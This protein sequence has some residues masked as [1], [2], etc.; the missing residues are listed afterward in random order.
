MKNKK[1]VRQFQKHIIITLII[2]AA[3]SVLTVLAIT[4]WRTQILPDDSELFVDITSTF[5]DGKSR[6]ETFS[7]QMKN[8]DGSQKFEQKNDVTCGSEPSVDITDDESEIVLLVGVSGA[9]ANENVLVLDPSEVQTGTSLSVANVQNGF[10]KLPK[11]KQQ[12]YTILGYLRFILPVVYSLFGII[13]SCYVFYRMHMKKTI[14]ELETA[15]EKISN[16]N[17]DFEITTSSRN[18][19][20]RLCDS[21]EQMR[22][23]L[24]KSNTEMFQMVEERRRLQS[25]V[26]HD[27]R[28]PI[29]IMKGYL[30]MMASESADCDSYKSE[31]ETLCL[32]VNRMEEY[33]D[34]VSEINKLEDM[35]LDLKEETIGECAE[36]W[37]R[38][39]ELL[40]GESSIKVQVNHAL[41][42]A[43]ATKAW[44]IDVNAITRILENVITNSLRYASSNIEVL[45]RMDRQDEPDGQQMLVFDI[46]DDG[47]GYPS[48]LLKNPDLYF[49][50]TEKSSGHMGMGMTICRI[51]CKKHQGSIE[52]SNNP[53]GGART[54][55]KIKN[56]KPVD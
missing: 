7:M 13:L 33:V 16:Q 31:I 50:T 25:S 3:L 19:L 9:G 52:F 54:I 24:V 21:F 42:E 47:P 17:L 36:R 51:I 44:Q 29:A 35:E 15:T 22:K 41:T 1:I 2:I 12:N 11:S 46:Q 40:A 14:E 26:A 5:A 32:T 45:V 8:A 43:D 37:Q 39:I 4:Q 18:E 23:A 56:M 20:G 49:Y 34:S 48:K 38:D 10:S 6:T 30:E 27:L 28:N 53:E 55:I